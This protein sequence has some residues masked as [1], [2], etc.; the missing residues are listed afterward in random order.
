MFFYCPANKNLEY[1]GQSPFIRENSLNHQ[2]LPQNKEVEKLQLAKRTG[3]PVQKP[4]I[5]RRTEPIGKMEV[6][7]VYKTPIIEAGCSKTVLHKIRLCSKLYAELVSKPKLAHKVKKLQ[8]HFLLKGYRRFLEVWLSST[9]PALVIVCREEFFSR[10]YAVVMNYAATIGIDHYFPR[11]SEQSKMAL[12]TA[13]PNEQVQ[14]PSLEEC[15]ASMRPQEAHF[16]RAELE[17]TGKSPVTT[18][19]NRK[20]IILIP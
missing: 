5:A 13:S 18:A 3:P 1:N 7:E 12:V 8:K 14:P 11:L 19:C 16:P 10:S 4:Q 9:K 17:E 2:S 20:K 6:G 15:G